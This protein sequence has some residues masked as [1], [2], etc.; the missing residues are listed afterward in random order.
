MPFEDAAAFLWC[1]SWN[2]QALKADDNAN[3]ISAFGKR[4]A[5]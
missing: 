3:T 2:K 5:A 4:P 1:G